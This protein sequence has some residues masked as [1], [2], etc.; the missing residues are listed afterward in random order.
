MRE[1][2]ARAYKWGESMAGHSKWANIKHKKAK[3]DAA[4]GKIFTRIGRELMVAVRNGGPD[5]NV[6]FRLKI[7]M[8]KA[9]AAN[10]PNDNIMR[11]IARASGSQEGANYE[12]FLYEGYGPAGVAVML[13][14]LTDNRNRT[15]S[16]IRY[17]FS[18]HGGNLGET[19]CVAWMFD[20]K[21]SLVLSLSELTK[22]VDEIMLEALEAGAEDVKEDEDTIQILTTPADFQTVKEAMEGQGYV[23]ASAE[24]ARIPQ[25]TVEVTDPNDAEKLLKLMDALEDHDDVQNVYSNF[26]IPDEIMAAFEN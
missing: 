18:R 15:A 12:E 25:N 9:R 26:D 17:L 7:V 21:G 3:A 4:K 5:P 6:N 8:D 23:F 20:Q 19:G 13:E 11:A 24:I 2:S 14:I 22:S 1:M 16:E 10:M